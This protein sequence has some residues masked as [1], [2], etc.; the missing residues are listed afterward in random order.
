MEPCDRV[1]LAGLASRL[2]FRFQIHQMDL[3]VNCAKAPL[4]V[5][6]LPVAFVPRI[7]LPR[8]HY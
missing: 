4:S 1:R 6:H 3:T 5:S 2:I 7:G 8:P